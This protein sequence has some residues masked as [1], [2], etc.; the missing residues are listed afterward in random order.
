MLKNSLFSS[1]LVPDAIVPQDFFFLFDRNACM[2]Y[3]VKGRELICYQALMGI[4]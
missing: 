3:Q 2:C 4:S 1:V